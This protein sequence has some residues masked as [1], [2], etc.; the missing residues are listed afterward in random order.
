MGTIWKQ[1]MATLQMW[2]GR[3]GGRSNTDLNAQGRPEEAVDVWRPKW[4][5]ETALWRSGKRTFQEA[6][7]ANALGDKH[8]MFEE[9]NQGH[10]SIWSLYGVGWGKEEADRQVGTGPCIVLQVLV[11]HLYFIL[12][13]MGRHEWVL[14][15]RMGFQ[16]SGATVGT[17]P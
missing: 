5:R 11:R 12:S 15:G 14:A 13:V 17:S 10:I 16:E 1:N 3:R 4:Q 8:S 9:Q 7:A 2:Q 6:A